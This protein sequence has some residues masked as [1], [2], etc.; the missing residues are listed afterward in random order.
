MK[1]KFMA[2]PMSKLA[3]RWTIEETELFAENLADPDYGFAQSLE[4]LALKK[5]SNDEV[6]GILNVNSSKVC[7]V[8]ALD[9]A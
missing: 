1:A 4:R 9:I 5:S 3:R 7:R 8:I 6:S 2:K